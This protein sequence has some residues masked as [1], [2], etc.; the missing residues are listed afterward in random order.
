MLEFKRKNSRS[1]N[2][3]KSWTTNFLLGQL[4][5][6]PFVLTSNPSCRGKNAD[7]MIRLGYAGDSRRI[8]ELDLSRIDSKHWFLPH[9]P[10][11]KKTEKQHMSSI[12]LNFCFHVFRWY[13]RAHLDSLCFPRIFLAV[14]PW[15][16]VILRPSAVAQ[17]ASGD[18]APY[19]ALVEEFY[20]W[21]RYSIP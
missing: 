10:H 4:V 18:K 2:P 16:T 12:C 20:E 15:A 13:C 8:S 5:R 11:Q 1:T 6:T 7:S 9:H 17:R 19:I 21:V 3:R 14:D